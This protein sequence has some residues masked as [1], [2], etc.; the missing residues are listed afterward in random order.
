MLA[1]KHW[2]HLRSAFGFVLN[3]ADV[4]WFATMRRRRSPSRLA[5]LLLNSHSTAQTYRADL[6]RRLT[7]Q[8]VSTMQRS[9][10]SRVSLWQPR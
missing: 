9:L 6:P 10:R 7:A 2:T 3:P 4:G 5:F 8:I 1:T